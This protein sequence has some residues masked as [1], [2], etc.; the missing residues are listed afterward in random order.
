MKLFTKVCLVLV[1]LFTS[2][3]IFAEWVYVPMS[4]NANK[5]DVVLSTSPGF[6]MDLLAILGCYWSHSGMAVDNGFNIRHNT[7]YV[8]EIPIEYNKIWFIQTTP[9]RMNPTRLSNGLPGILT[10]DIDTAYNATNNFAA[11]GG[12]VLKPTA[13]NEAAYRQYLNAAADVFNYLKA[14]Y[15][16]NAYVNM[17]QLDYANYLI[18]GRGNHCSGTCWYAN[19][20]SGKTMVVATIPANLV[21][22]CANSLYTSVKNMVRDE[23]GGFGAFIIDIEGLFGTG[24]DEKIANQIVNTFGFD[25]ATDTSDYW[26]S[27]IGAVTATANAPDHLILSS[28]TNPSGHNVGAQTTS[29]SYYGQVE[30]LVITD[31]YYI[32]IP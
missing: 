13:A 14:Y 29:T 10:E 12:A 27:Y 24:A 15:R 20:F 11:A 25:R 23:A 3:T 2:S 16:V 19:Y 28:Y 8:S 1:L 7:M 30:P 6:I 21:T 32:E 26:R 31:G 18:T 5:G 9:K 22:Q 17:Y 4:I